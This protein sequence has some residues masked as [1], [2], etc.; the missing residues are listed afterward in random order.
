MSQEFI[1]HVT[2]DLPHLVNDQWMYNEG[3]ESDYVN[4]NGA[5][6]NTGWEE[7]HNVTLLVHIRSSSGRSMKNTEFF[8]GEI[9]SLRYKAFNINIKYSGEVADVSAGIG[10][11]PEED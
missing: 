11:D 3:V 4:Y 1:D 5:V 10:W 8:I 9:K 7:M 6:F 2:Q